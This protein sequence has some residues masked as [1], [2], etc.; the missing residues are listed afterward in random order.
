VGDTE[1]HFGTGGGGFGLEVAAVGV[2]FIFRLGFVF[3]AF[4]VAFVVVAFVVVVVGGVADIL[5]WLWWCIVETVLYSERVRFVMCSL[6]C[7]MF[8]KRL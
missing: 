7:V 4:I 5:V 1:R 6:F 8:V 3:I 2:V